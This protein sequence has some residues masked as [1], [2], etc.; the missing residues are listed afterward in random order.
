[1]TIGSENLAVPGA[2]GKYTLC[3]QQ[4]HYVLTITIVLMDRLFA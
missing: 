4:I 3:D 1:L 2:S